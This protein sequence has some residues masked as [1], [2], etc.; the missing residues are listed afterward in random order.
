LGNRHKL[1]KPRLP[2]AFISW[3]DGG[4]EVLLAAGGPEIGETAISAAAHGY[5]HIAVPI[6]PFVGLLNGIDAERVVLNSAAPMLPIRITKVEGDGFL[7]LQS[8]VRP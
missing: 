2:F 3:T 6:G 8:L 7:A 1:K 4:D 5:A